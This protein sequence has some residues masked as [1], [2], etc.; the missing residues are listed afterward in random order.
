MSASSSTSKMDRV[1]F[2]TLVSTST[3]PQHDV[4]ALPRPCPCPGSAPMRQTGAVHE[5]RMSG[6]SQLPGSEDEAD[7]RTNEEG[8][9]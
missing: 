7:I 2:D 9:C 1:A 5:R 4:R 3:K 6:S 8:A